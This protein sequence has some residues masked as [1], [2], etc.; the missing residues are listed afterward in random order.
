MFTVI[1]PVSGAQ[2][3]PVK[4]AFLEGQLVNVDFEQPQG[5]E[6]VY[7]VGPWRF[8]ATLKRPTAGKP[9]KPHDKRL[10]LYIVAPGKQNQSGSVPEFD[11]NVI[12]NGKP[13]AD[14]AP[15]EFD[16]YWAVVL[17]PKLRAD[18]RHERDL[19]IAAQEEFIT[20]DLFDF[21]DFAGAAFLRTVL[22]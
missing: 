19:L 12:V 20:G 17:D 21:D 2:D 6:R 8:G 5:K 13:L 10:N 1:A 7:A 22:K 18:P 4:M 9:D 15:A 16:V 3:R 11:H 14:D